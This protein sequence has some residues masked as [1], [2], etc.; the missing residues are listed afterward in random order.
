MGPKTEILTVAYNAEK[1]IERAIESIINQ[2]YKNFSYT[3]FDNGS[4]DS[5]RTIIE[6]YSKSD[7]RITLSARDTNDKHSFFQLLP[8][9][10]NR[11]DK[12]SCFV[13][14]DADDAY[15]SDFLSRSIEFMKLHDCDIVCVGSRGID[16]QSGNQIGDRMLNH[17]AIVENDK[18]FDKGFPFYYPFMRTVW[19]K[20][21]RAELLKKCDFSEVEKVYYG[22]DTIFGMEVFKHANRVGILSGTL[23]DYYISHKSVSYKFD[24]K[25]IASDRVLYEMARG[26]LNSKVGHISARNYDYLL[27]V[28]FQAFADTIEVIL[29]SD[30]SDKEKKDSVM[31]IFNHKYT[32]SVMQANDLGGLN[33]NR[34]TISQR[35]QSLLPRVYGILTSDDEVIK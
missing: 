25:R 10:L 12:D 6:R 11:C 3:V 13:T 20:L 24:S 30:L 15:D 35:K 33:G 26:Y 16:A 4:T 7:S 21:C 28:Y 31:D 32:K 1:T 9:I 8:D 22:G 34:T 14:L 23:H 27:T 2:S 5:T 19:G 29:G 18:D 17:D